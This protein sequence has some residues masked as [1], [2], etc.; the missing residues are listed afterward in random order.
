MTSVA[1]PVP[2]PS[3]ASRLRVAPG[4]V[5]LSPFVHLAGSVATETVTGQVYALA[6][7]EARLLSACADG[8]PVA[9]FSARDREV[10]SAL[11]QRLLLLTEGS[12]AAIGA[13]ALGEID[14][15]VAGSCNAECIFCPREE[16]RQ[17]RGVGVMSEATFARVVEIFGPHLRFVG[18]A[19]I[20]E[21]T[22]HR[23]LPQQIRA[24]T[25]RGIE[26]ALVTNGSRLTDSLL[27]EIIAA[28]VGSVQVSFNGNDPESYEDHMVGL[29]FA[30][31]RARVERLIE[32]ARP[33]GI[34]VSISAVETTRNQEQL[35][36][37]V[38]HWRSLGA[39]AGVVV[40]HSRGGTIVELVPRRP[41]PAPPPPAPRC[42]LFNARCF[43]SWDGL[44]LACCHDVDGQT[45]LGDVN[46]DDAATLIARK[47]E[48]MRRREWF[49][50]CHGCDEPARLR[51]FEPAE[52]RQ[53]S[54]PRTSR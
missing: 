47:L 33:A 30:E 9:T 41:A 34:P 38:E 39:D 48:V 46:R 22:L 20:G 15:E 8:V 19:G 21:P 32:L 44:V 10:A 43:V 24:F 13:L 12:L 52:L 4:L 18:F 17:G 50:V 37:F 40:C 26:V 54:S 35:A 53:R 14:L 28:G 25:S 16:L 42:G 6:P 23:A 45:V 2:E 49:P 27:A 51:Q 7:D 11:V 3:D 1:L 29:D 31:T 36:G 5:R